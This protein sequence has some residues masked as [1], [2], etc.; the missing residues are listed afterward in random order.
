MEG[1]GIIHISNISDFIVPSQECILSL[2]KSGPSESNVAIHKKPERDEKSSKKPRSL[3]NK[4][5]VSLNDCLACSGCITSAETVLIQ[6]QSSEVF[7]SSVG[8]YTLSVVTIAP[9]SI[10]SI[11]AKRRIDSCEAASLLFSFFDSL[12]VTYVIDAG[13]ARYLT[14][15]LSFEEFLESALP[16]PIFTSSCPGFVCY[17]EKTQG[18]LLTPHIS[19][20]RSPQ[21]IMGSLVKDYLSRSL[22]I[23]PEKIYHVSVMPC[24][25]KKLEASRSDFSKSGIRQV[26]CVLST[27][28]V[29]AMLDGYEKHGNS[30]AN[31]PFD[32]L[33]SL[34]R[35]LVIGS[36][37]GSTSGGYAEYIVGRFQ[38]RLSGKISVSRSK[39]V[40]NLEIIEVFEDDCLRL[41]AVKCYG[42]RNI[43]NLVQKMRRG[44]CAFD[45]VEIMACPSGC[46][47]GGG[48]VRGETRQV[49]DE[50]LRRTEDVYGELRPVEELERELYRVVDE[51]KS[52]NMDWRESLFTSYHIIDTDSDLRW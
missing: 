48:Q 16:K 41:T 20:V 15:S 8:K 23:S 14:L 22:D 47:N 21:A 40:K 33:H 42:F 17:A 10:A 18:K 12:G 43:Q 28:E 35:G 46:V 4:V 38:E 3:D 27:A 11:A 9:Q 50:L 36:G 37:H 2:R 52:L 1:G 29:N 6:E 7:L 45:Y 49:R 13:F 25:D 39:T 51:W 5:T 32:W 19:R 24:Y 31:G 34:S 44:K 30:K 26:D